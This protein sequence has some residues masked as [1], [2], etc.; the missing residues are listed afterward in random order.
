MILLSIITVT[1]NDFDR[2]KKTISS[3][4]SYYNDKFFEHIII[5]GNSSDKTISFIKK[6]LNKEK[7]IIF[8]SSN[9]N[10][11]Y[12]AMNSG[13]NYSKG[14][15]V[16][17][18][19]SGDEMLIEKSQIIAKLLELNNSKYDLICFPFIHDFRSYKLIKKPKKLLKHTLP[20]S[21]QAMF[22]SKKF[23]VQ[24]KY[25]TKYS[26]ASD[27]DIY[28]KI[29]SKKICL[30]ENFNP[31]SKVEGEGFATENKMKSYI[32]YVKIIVFYYSG[33]L[34]IYLVILI[35]LRFVITSFLSISMPDRFIFYLK[36]KLN[37]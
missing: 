20:T 23:F 11:I 32:E 6:K 2:L 30:I 17:F 10:G 4:R 37:K 5:D 21:H 12:D 8:K 9:D 18:L 31:L 27:F 14:S 15:F 24:N 19:N 25:N 26:V 28:Q 7:N 3:M 36:K 22:F 29:E 34:K 1:K 13:I 33:L 35:A 16:L